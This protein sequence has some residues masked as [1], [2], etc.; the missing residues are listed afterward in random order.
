M[1]SHDDGRTPPHLNLGVSHAQTLIIFSSHTGKLNP[2]YFH[3]R[4]RI[5]HLK[6]LMS[7][8]LNRAIL[9]AFTASVSA[10][11]PAM[12]A[13]L[14]T[15]ANPCSDCTILCGSSI[16]SEISFNLCDVSQNPICNSCLSTL[17]GISSSSLDGQAQ[18]PINCVDVGRSMNLS[19]VTRCPATAT[20]SGG[21]PG[22]LLEPQTSV[23]KTSFP[24][25]PAV[26]VSEVTDTPEPPKFP[27]WA[28]DP[29]T[30]FLTGT[31]PLAPR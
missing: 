31:T 9:F 10:Q 19:F 30:A 7:P 29:A 16:A 15:P 24:T 18:Q 1:I 11:L 25:D 28:G 6:P 26:Q 14:A 5:I 3:G 13:T 8:F 21:F 22:M 17:S 4:H 20:V 27:P 2:K 12:P 23:I